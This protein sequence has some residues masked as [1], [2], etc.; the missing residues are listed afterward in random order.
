MA[1]LEAVFPEPKFSADPLK[2]A[3][4]M[5][6]RAVVAALRHQYEKQ[7]SKESVQCASPAAR[8]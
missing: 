1:W 5:G 8:P 2:N 4:E 6:K 3:H 7:T